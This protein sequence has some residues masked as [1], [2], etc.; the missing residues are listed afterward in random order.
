MS[1]GH[2]EGAPRSYDAEMDQARPTQTRGPS[3]D[4][5]LAGLVVL[6]ALAV[7]AGLNGLDLGTADSRWSLPRQLAYLPVL[8]I[9]WWIGRRRDLPRHGVPTL[10]AVLAGLTVVAG[11]I[12][13]PGWAATVVVYTGLAVVIPWLSGHALRRRDLLAAA[14]RSQVEQAQQTREAY[15]ELAR[16]NAGERL[17]QDVHDM[18]GHDLALIALQAGRLELTVAPDAK[19]EAAQLRQL[20][21]DATDRLRGY[22]AAGRTVPA[23]T[24]VGD[25]VDRARRSGLSISLDGDG[26]RPLLIRAAAEC[27][28]NAVRHAPGAAVRVDITAGRMTVTNPLADRPAA[29]QGSGLTQ[30]KQLIEA[31]GG[32]L[33]AGE[34]DG[35]WVVRVSVTA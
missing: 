7:A 12:G 16:V 27:I 6:L 26:T 22:L 28:A 33:E 21:L 2:S 18:L 1:Q 32:S 29:R 20:A 8:G 3:A 5:R 15:A 23:P 10:V 4:P 19:P 31:D 11:L 17:A 25:V 30:L 24:S 34:R 14:L 35:H 13:G 9:A